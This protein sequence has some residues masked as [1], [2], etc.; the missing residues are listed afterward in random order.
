LTLQVTMIL[1]S[2]H[3]FTLPLE[4]AWDYSRELYQIVHFFLGVSLLILS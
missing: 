1:V 4:G 3:E 2:A